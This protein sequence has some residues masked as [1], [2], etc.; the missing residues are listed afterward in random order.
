MNNRLRSLFLG[1]LVLG[2]LSLT[3]CKPEY[4]ACDTDKD[5]KD[6]EFCVARKC[7]QCRDNADCG[8][9]KQCAAGKCSAIVGWCKD[10]SQC[11]AGQE[12]IANMCRACQDDGECP[13]GLI[14][15][16]GSCQN[17]QCKTDDDCAQDQECQKGRCASV[18]KAPAAGPPCPLAPIYFGFDQTALSTDASGVLQSNAACLKKT[19]R[20]VNLV[21]RAD[22]RGTPEYNLALSDKRAQAVREYLQRLGIGAGRLIPVPRGELD[23][24]GSDEATWAQDRRVDSEWQ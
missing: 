17:P 15:L 16:A 9:G 12:C 3:G 4:P 6:K 21:G 5:C 11:A 10:K 18:R 19:E 1:A 23:A 20:S 22:A 2:A 7:Q 13:S 14:C 8:E 24:S